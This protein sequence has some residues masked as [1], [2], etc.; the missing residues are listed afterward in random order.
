MGDH[1]QDSLVYWLG[2]GIR[3]LFWLFG[4]Y[5]AAR[6]LPSFLRGRVDGGV[7]VGAIL[8]LYVLMWMSMP[9]ALVVVQH[10]TPHPNAAQCTPIRPGTRPTLPTG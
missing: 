3:V 8:S 2:L 5:I 10:R 6:M 9:T 7:S 4:A 1:K